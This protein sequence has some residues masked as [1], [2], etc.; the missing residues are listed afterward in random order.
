[1]TVPPALTEAWAAAG[2]ACVRMNS[3]GLKSGSQTSNAA[4]VEIGTNIVW[5]V[6]G[7]NISGWPCTNWWQ[8]WRTI[9]CLWG[10]ATAMNS[11]PMKV[12]EMLACEIWTHRCW[13]RKLITTVGYKGIGPEI[14]RAHVGTLFTNAHI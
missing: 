1:M 5:S 10:R 12:H 7:K 3:A 2:Y 13:S 14:G 8:E 4:T 11:V 6:L 9:C